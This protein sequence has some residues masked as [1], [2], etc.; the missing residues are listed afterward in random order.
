MEIDAW[1]VSGFTDGEGSFLVSFSPR[2]RIA[3]G[4][5]TRPSFTISQHQ[6]SANV[7][8]GIQEFFRCGTIRFNSSDETYKYEVRSLED[9]ASRII[10]HF[11][12]YPLQ[13]SKQSDFEIW[14]DI[15][16]RMMKKEHLDKAGLKNI[17]HVAYDMNNNGARRY[18]IEDLLTM[19][20]KIKV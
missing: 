5:E 18:K 8:S 11:E 17:I 1:Y 14:K 4:I 2:G 13:T 6:R 16:R 9:I 15:C 20:G 19:C 10:P 7:L 3:I 12:R